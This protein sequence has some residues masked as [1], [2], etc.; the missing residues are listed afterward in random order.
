VSKAGTKS[1]SRS[2][3]SVVFC[4]VGERPAGGQDAGQCAAADHI[5]GPAQIAAVCASDAAGMTIVNFKG[6]ARA[7][8]SNVAA[9]TR[10]VSA[11]EFW[12]GL[13]KIIKTSQMHR[14]CMHFRVRVLPAQPRSVVSAELAGASNPRTLTVAVNNSSPP[15]LSTPDLKKLP[16]KR[17]PDFYKGSW[18]FWPS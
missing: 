13:R 18:V 4:R 16:E 7:A 2:Q 8:S 6:P 11:G 10:I 12:A 14:S 3:C 1:P 17:P 5:S 15:N 9:Q